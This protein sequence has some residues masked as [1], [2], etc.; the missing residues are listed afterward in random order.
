LFP[1]ARTTSKMKE[2]VVSKDLKVIIQDVDF[3]TIP[4]PAHLIIKVN[5]SG[6]NPKDW[7][8]AE[9]CECSVTFIRAEPS[10]DRFCM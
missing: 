6:S 1:T 9:R 3:P 4:S 10:A 2:A 8:M 5:V 7:A